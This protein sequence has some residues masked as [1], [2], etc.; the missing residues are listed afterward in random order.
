MS[1]DRKGVSR[2]ELL[3]FWRRPL[4]EM[5]QPSAPPAPRSP[6]LRPPGTTHELMLLNSCLRC[7]RCVEA[8]PAQAI[9]PLGPEWGDKQRT[10]AINARR[11][12]CVLC[13]GLKC[14]HVCPS[15]ALQPLFDENEVAMG[16]AV[17]DP[18]R[19]VAYH[20]QACDACHRACPIPGA[21]VVEPDGR[22][23]VEEPLC[24][25]CGLCEHVCPTGPASVRVVPRD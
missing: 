19:C 20:G 13:T 16:R 6:P 1:K 11:Q 17:L 22:V 24:V 23:R 2:R 8:C 21:I 3:T 25:G 12:P 10:P 7:G 9:F 18:D 15:G 14:T 5:N 4:A